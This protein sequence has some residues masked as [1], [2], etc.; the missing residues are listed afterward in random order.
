M[1]LIGQVVSE[2]MFEIVDRRRTDDNEQT[3][4]HG[5]S[6]SSPCEPN[7]SG[8]L[9]KNVRYLKF[10]IQEVDGLYYPCSKT[11]ALISFAVIATL[12]CAFVLVYSKSLLIT[13][14]IYCYVLK[15]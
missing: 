3:P 12:V 11:K 2:K 8:E 4:E 5:Y 7:G 6:I 9:K 13:G 1:A 15:M 14:L 10:R